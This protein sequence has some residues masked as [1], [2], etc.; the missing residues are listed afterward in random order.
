MALEKFVLIVGA[1]HQIVHHEE[2]CDHAIALAIFRH[3]PNALLGDSAWRSAG[4]VLALDKETAVI[5]GT[6]AGQRFYQFRLSIALYTG[7][8]EDLTALQAQV[9][10]F[11]CRQT[12]IV[13]HVQIDDI[14]DFVAA[15][16]C[17]IFHFQY[18]VATHHQ[19][20]QGLLGGLLGIGMAGD[21]AASQHNNVVADFQ[22]FFQLMADENDADAFFQQRVHDL[23]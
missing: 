7:D 9:D 2:A 3:V 21:L 11:H 14:K 17:G 8:A 16:R 19:R 22:H 1:K 23:E 5:N 18:H 10:A 15:G 6:H 20:C 12:A 13:V 4:H